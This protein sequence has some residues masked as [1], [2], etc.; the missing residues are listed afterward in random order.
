MPVHAWRV[1]YLALA[2]LFGLR[3]P[4]P[5]LQ[6][7]PVA[8]PRNHPY[9]DHE[10]AGDGN[11]LAKRLTGGGYIPASATAHR[12]CRPSQRSIRRE[13]NRL[14]FRQDRDSGPGH[15]RPLEDIGTVVNAGAVNVL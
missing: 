8:R 3:R 1:T 6:V 15:R 7:P 11:L 4:A 13:L 12:G 9:L 14:E 10:V 5:Q 2:R